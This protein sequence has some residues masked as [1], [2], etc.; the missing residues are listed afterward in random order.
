MSMPS[1]ASNPFSPNFN[2]QKAVQAALT[3]LTSGQ[4]PKTSELAAFK[5]GLYAGKTQ[6]SKD[7]MSQ[8]QALPK[9]LLKSMGASIPASASMNSFM[10][11]PYAMNA[12]YDILSEM[13]DGPTKAEIAEAVTEEIRIQEKVEK[14][15]KKLDAWKQVT[16]SQVKGLLKSDSEINKIHEKLA[17]KKREHD[18]FVKEQEAIKKR[19]AQFGLDPAT[20]SEKGIQAQI[21]KVMAKISKG[22]GGA[23]ALLVLR[24][25]LALVKSIDPNNEWEKV[26][27]KISKNEE[28]QSDLKGKRLEILCSKTAEPPKPDSEIADRVSVPS[29]S[30]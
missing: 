28:K 1:N 17:E 3:Q 15:E 14:Y 29:K 20:D 24:L 13:E 27:E 18:S 23:L 26:C 22:E 16:E 9:G 4:S 6:A 8:F 7:L 11:N 10:N 21:D 30:H 19:Y 25:K 12:F 5:Q 2:M